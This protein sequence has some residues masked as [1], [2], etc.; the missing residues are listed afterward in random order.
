MKCRSQRAAAA[1]QVRD[2]TPSNAWARKMPAP[3]KPIAAVNISNIAIVLVR[4]R[5]CTPNAVQ[6]RTVKNISSRGHTMRRK[7]CF[8]ATDVSKPVTHGLR[9]WRKSNDWVTIAKPSP[10]PP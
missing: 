1:V 7:W 2:K 3:T 5:A 10:F 8:G 6:A 9:E 4:P